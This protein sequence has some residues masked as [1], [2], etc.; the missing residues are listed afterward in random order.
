MS[1]VAYCEIS[2]E[3]SPY[4]RPNLQKL[5]IIPQ[6]ENYTSNYEKRIFPIPVSLT[7]WSHLR[8]EGDLYH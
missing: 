8:G 2:P 4:H 7:F 3:D 6:L 1:Q 5:K